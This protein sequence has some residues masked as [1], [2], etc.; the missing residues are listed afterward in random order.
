MKRT[1]LILAAAVQSLIAAAATAQIMPARAIAPVNPIAGLPRML[2]SP[3]SGPLAGISISLPSAVPALTPAP[4]LLP[5]PAALA[6][7]AL[8]ASLPTRRVPVLPA[9]PSRDGVNNPVRRIIPGV[10]VRF[11]EPAPK[12]EKA[13]PEQRRDELDQ[14]FDGDKQLPKPAVDRGPIGHER[15]ISLP[16]DD[17]MRELGF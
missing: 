9:G 8:P 4:A 5:A 3:L 14:L 1:T 6:P 16:E 10:V 12:S 2:P 17:L 15:R 13:A 11:A 7:S